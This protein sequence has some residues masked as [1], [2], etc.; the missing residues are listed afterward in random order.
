MPE[1]PKAAVEQGLTGERKGADPA[2]GRAQRGPRT[3]TQGPVRHGGRTDE[4]G[5]SPRESPGGQRELRGD[6]AS[7]GLDGEAAPR[8]RALGQVVASGRR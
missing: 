4:E 1:S 3:A 6:R 8:S 7:L 2:G 5:P